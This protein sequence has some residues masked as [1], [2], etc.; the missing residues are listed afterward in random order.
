MLP[1]VEKSEQTA[2][3]SSSAAK[4][5]QC[6]HYQYDANYEEYTCEMDLDEDEMEK[7]ITDRFGDCPYYDP[8][9]EYKIVR[10]QM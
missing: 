9:D 4:C 2:R 1:P 7:F 8:D 6:A 3:D 10:H 5:E